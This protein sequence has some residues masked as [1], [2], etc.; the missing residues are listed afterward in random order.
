MSAQSRARAWSLGRAV[1]LLSIFIGASAIA[2]CG[3]EYNSI[4]RTENLDDGTSLIT[5]AKQ[6]VIINSKNFRTDREG[7]R[8]ICAEP[9][10]D[11]AQA[12]SA[13]LKVSAN[14]A[15]TSGASKTDAAAGLAIA[16]AAQVAQLGERLTTIQ[17][18]RERMYRACEAYANGATTASQYRSMLTTIDRLM[19]TTLSAE[20]AAGAFGRNLAVA[21]TQAGTGGGDPAAF[22]K[23]TKEVGETAKALED[24]AAANPP[25]AADVAAKS[26]AFREALAR[27]E[28]ANVVAGAVGTG[29]QPGQISG[30][31]RTADAGAIV[32]IH[33]NYIDD[34]RVEGL[35][36]ACISTMSE[37]RY[38][39]IDYRSYLDGVAK[40]RAKIAAAYHRGPTFG[41]LIAGTNRPDPLKKERD[42]A[43]RAYDERT[44]IS[45]ET[46]MQQRTDFTKYC[47]DNVFGDANRTIRP[48]TPPSM[49]PPGIAPFIMERMRF[50]E[51]LR[52]ISEPSK[53][54]QLCFSILD[55][56]AKEPKNTDLQA[57]AKYCR[58]LLN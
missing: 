19:A 57:Q 31:G 21:S 15:S 16:T 1:G 12:V 20:M 32:A 11:V 4:F 51:R 9:S 34:D 27:L 29:G 13:A 25:V 18:M 26:K 22:A 50:K 58:A 10:P 3:D 17:G 40:E 43:L 47:K 6:R 30:T 42:D 49:I 23:L 38:A 5:D 24:A 52:Q 39:D 56:A 36:D 54:A 8:I 53:V 37:V 46:F 33:R 28:G 48:G 35:I 44:L 55:R 45:R 7:H 14:L 41:E 2:A